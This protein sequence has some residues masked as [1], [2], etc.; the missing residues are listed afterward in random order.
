MHEVS[1]RIRTATGKHA[2]RDFRTSLDACFPTHSHVRISAKGDSEDRVL[3]RE[4]RH[5][6]THVRCI[7]MGCRPVGPAHVGRRSTKIVGAS[8]HDGDVSCGAADVW[9]CSIE[10][11]VCGA[12]GLGVMHHRFLG[13]P[14]VSSLIRTVACAH[15]R[16]QTG[17]RLSGCAADTP[18]AESACRDVRT[19]RSHPQEH[20]WR[21]WLPAW[22]EV[23]GRQ[24]HCHG[25]TDNWTTFSSCIHFFRRHSCRWRRST[26]G[27]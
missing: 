7:C 4:F 23:R 13:R 5:L 25:K 10:R 15:G 3:G 17:G 26:R 12:Q 1:L 14:V 27:R 22:S 20:T 21:P 19:R 2:S 8:C 18:D 6:C 16:G 9:I 24:A 11:R